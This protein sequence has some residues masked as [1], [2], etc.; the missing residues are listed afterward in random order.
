MRGEPRLAVRNE[1][2]KLM[3]KSGKP[4][5][6]IDVVNASTVDASIQAKGIGQKIRRL[7]LKRSMGLVELGQMVGLSASFLSQLETGRVIPTMRNLARIAMAFKKDLAYFLAEEETNALF[8]ISRAKDRIRLPV[9]E[10]EETFL[11]SDSMNVLLQHPNTVPCVA[12]F[13][14]GI[15][16]AAFSPQVF[17]GL[18]L[19]YVIEG[20]LVL[21]TGEKTELL[22]AQDSAWIDGNATRKYECRD[23]KRARAL[24][25]TFALGI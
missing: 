6:S 1:F 10:K 21:S 8:R 16:N 12:E 14:P 19:V 9:G 3:A 7:R 4:G 22:E 13:V 18:E 17:P 15:E 2:W 23:H 25:M 20:T 24:I 5:P 11:Y